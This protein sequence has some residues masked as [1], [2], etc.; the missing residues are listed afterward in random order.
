MDTQLD[1]IKMSCVVIGPALMDGESSGRV[2]LPVVDSLT[3]V[4]EMKSL[5]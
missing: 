5:N 3:G 2:F 4:V 1:S